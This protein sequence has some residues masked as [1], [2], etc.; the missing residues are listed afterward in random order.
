MVEWGCRN[1]AIVFSFTTI[2]ERQ[3]FLSQINPIDLFVKME[4][5]L[6]QT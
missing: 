3:L 5:L 6:R 1:Q 4:S 2:F